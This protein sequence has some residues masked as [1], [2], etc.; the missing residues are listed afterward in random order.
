MAEVDTEQ[1]NQDVK[2]REA[3]EEELKHQNERREEAMKKVRI[4]RERILKGPSLR[5]LVDVPELDK[6]EGKAHFVI[7][8]LT[9]NEYFEMQKTVLGDLS[10]RSI[11]ADDGLLAAQIV[12]NEKSGR[13]LA[14]SYALSID[15][16]KWTPG[17]VGRLPPGVPEKLFERLAEI[18]G[19]PRPSTSAYPP[20]KTS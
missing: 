18:S 7:R 6:E 20:K 1:R 9:D 12:E 15:K 19:F 16:D 11:E 17:E 3:F 10:R 5:E 4:T 14:L 8:P 2:D 13:Y